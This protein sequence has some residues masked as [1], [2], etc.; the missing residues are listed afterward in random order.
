M[1]E[2]AAVAV[3]VAVAVTLERK[4]GITGVPFGRTEVSIPLFEVFFEIYRTGTTVP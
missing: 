1:T 2:A 4:M 3:A